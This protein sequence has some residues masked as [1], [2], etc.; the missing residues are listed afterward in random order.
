ML[1]TKQGSLSLASHHLRESPIP[2][3]SETSRSSVFGCSG[4][5]V[6]PHVRWSVVVSI[7]RQA[8][9]YD[10]WRIFQKMELEGL[11]LWVHLDG[12]SGDDEREVGC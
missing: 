12:E 4:S 10:L 7:K 5:C 2:V 9:C 1:S 11:I 3:R 8:K 6:R